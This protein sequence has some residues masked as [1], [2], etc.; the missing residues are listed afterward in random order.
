MTLY[1]DDT[2]IPNSEDLYR[3]IH[4]SQ[5]KLVENTHTFR[6]TSA[7]FKDHRCQISVDLSS[8]TTPQDALAR[9]SQKEIKYAL[10]AVTAGDARQ[11]EQKII[12]DPAPNDP[13]HALIVG[14]Q[15]PH[16]SKA[17]AQAAKWIIPPT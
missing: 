2:T 15:P 11:I 5:W 16:V 8:L 7:A 4:P 17:L 14:Q 3:R 13:A 6:V 9:A 10:A 1:I 12:R